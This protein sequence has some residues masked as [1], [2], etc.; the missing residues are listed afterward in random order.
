MR[1]QP[2]HPVTI[3]RNDEPKEGGPKRH[4]ARKPPSLSL[5]LRRERCYLETRNMPLSRERRYLEDRNMPLSRERCYLEDR[6][7]PLSR[8]RVTFSGKSQ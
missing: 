2:S 3:A 6:N 4:G 1:E 8:E 5:P 7:V